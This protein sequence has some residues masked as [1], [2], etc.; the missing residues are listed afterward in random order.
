MSGYFVKFRSLYWYCSFQSAPVPEVPPDS[1]LPVGMSL[2]DFHKCRGLRCDQ[3]KRVQSKIL[4]M[5]MLTIQEKNLDTGNIAYDLPKV[6]IKRLI[7]KSI[8]YLSLKTF[9]DKGSLR[10][11]FLVAK[12]SHTILWENISFC[13]KCIKSQYLCVDI[14]HTVWCHCIFYN[15]SPIHH[16]GFSGKILH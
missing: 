9:V 6:C 13:V 12:K 1:W 4:E 8:S 10:E 3:Y 2:E 14:N 15:A 11:F 5:Q 16:H 7:Y